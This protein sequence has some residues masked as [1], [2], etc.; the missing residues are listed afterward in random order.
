MV[1]GAAVVLGSIG[2]APIAAAADPPAPIV[3][4]RGSLGR[5]SVE[6]TTES[7]VPID[8]ASVT[9]VDDEDV[10]V[11]SG[12]TDELGGL[13]IDVDPGHYDVEVIVEDWA[14]PE[15][16][17]T[18]RSV[19]VFQ[20]DLRPN[21]ASGPNPRLAPSATYGPDPDVEGY[22]A[23]DATYEANHPQCEAGTSKLFCQ[24][25]EIWHPIGSDGGGRTSI[26]VRDGTQLD[27]LVQLPPGDGPFPVV[28]EYSLYEDVIGQ[29]DGNYQRGRRAGATST[30]G[31]RW[32]TRS[33]GCR[34]A[35]SAAPAAGGI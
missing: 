24:E 10:Q 28:L 25:L 17:S 15:D 35:A 9:I 29:G 16:W 14:G 11:A 12:Q 19:N 22:G 26:E 27:A 7:G 8:G 4:V 34:F 20:E 6:A 31:W 3:D 13:L 1:V 18:P 33:S 23:A 5:I 2:S 30:D 32:S 21:P